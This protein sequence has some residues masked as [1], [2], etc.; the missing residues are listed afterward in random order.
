MNKEDEKR[1]QVIQGIAELMRDNTFTFEYKVKKKPNG[2]RIICEVSQ[3]D[4]EEMVK[5]WQAKK[6]KTI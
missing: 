5:N 6:G 3:D 2:I 1:E 4:M